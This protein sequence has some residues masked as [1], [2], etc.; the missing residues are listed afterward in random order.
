MLFRYTL[1]L[2]AVC[3]FSLF[4]LI[5]AL[6]TPVFSI[7][8]DKPVYTYGDHLSLIFDVSKLLGNTITF[9]IIDD[10]GK[11]SSPI[12]IQVSKLKTE[13]TAPVA[14]YKTTFKTG[15][16]HINANYSGNNASTEFTLVDSGRIAIPTQYKNIVKL[17]LDSKQ[18]TDSNFA[19]V[20]RDLIQYDIIHIPE[21]KNQTTNTVHVPTWF[22]NNAKWWTDDLIS[23]NDFGLGIQYLIKANI[24]TV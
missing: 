4:G 23:D 17:W 11:A 9:Q 13:I 21:L 22:K 8:A 3:F 12:P 10:S 19:I 1:V 24:M 6:D 18:H 7:H 15:T 20:I 5:Y 2:S 14:F 16:Y